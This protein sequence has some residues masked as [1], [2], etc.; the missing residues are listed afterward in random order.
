MPLSI[1]PGRMREMAAQPA[2]PA[3]AAVTDED[4]SASLAGG[5]F[6]VLGKAMLGIAGAYLLRAVA[7]SS[8]LPRTA[9]AAVAIAYALGWLA[10]ASRAKAGDWLAGTTYACTS[11]LILAPML[12]E[13]TLRFNVLPAPV[14]AAVVCGFVLAASALAWK[15]DFAPVL[16]VANGTAVAI[17]LTLAI[18]SHQIGA[19]HCGASADG[20]DQASM[21]RPAI[22]RP[23]CGCWW[24][25]LRMWRSGR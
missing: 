10:W 2:S 23:A 16:W 22:G 9:V 6:S 5:A 12:W 15:R 7:E 11:A 13:L 14:S 25:W 17:A 18:A 24:R 8:S 20:A 21:E 1:Q 3:P 4:L 19:L